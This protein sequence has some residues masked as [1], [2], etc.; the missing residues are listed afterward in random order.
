MPVSRDS[1]IDP[2]RGTTLVKPLPIR[3]FATPP[4]PALDGPL[5]G[6]AAGPPA[7]RPAFAV[8]Q[9]AQEI[10]PRPSRRGERRD[11]RKGRG[12]GTKEAASPPTPRE[13]DENSRSSR[14][15][16]P[17]THP[18]TAGAPPAGKR[19]RPAPPRRHVPTRSLSDPISPSRL[20][21]DSL[22]ESTLAFLDDEEALSHVSFSYRAPALRPRVARTQSLVAAD[23][24]D[25]SPSESPHE[26]PVGT[27]SP[28]PPH[29]LSRRYTRSLSES[30][31][32]AR[33]PVQER[34]I[35]RFSSSSFSTTSSAPFLESD[36]RSAAVA[37]KRRKRRSFGGIGALAAPAP[38]PAGGEAGG[39]NTLALSP[40]GSDRLFEDL[41]FV[42]LER[43]LLER[44]ERSRPP[45]SPGPSP[46][47]GSSAPPP[48]RSR[49]EPLLAGVGG[50]R[51]GREMWIWSA[52]RRTRES[53][54]RGERRSGAPSFPPVLDRSRV[55][56]S[57]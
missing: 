22:A 41:V 50:L 39:P 27:S 32:S 30:F 18:P 17:P 45:P 38:G 57:D 53:Q 4:S 40:T 43:R 11:G 33:S 52:V 29:L 13:E 54:R 56:I 51:P 35:P 34:S 10:P 14:S 48:K 15:S 44:L 47:E 16:P 12:D 24:P 55:D 49:S 28:R 8:I 21:A 20:H 5:V 31:L 2:F 26:R 7:I 25:P 6:T 3:P 37:E 23:E 42:T 36:P 1:R 19:A 9:A 46:T